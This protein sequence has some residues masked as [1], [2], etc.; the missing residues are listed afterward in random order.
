MRS[1][2]KGTTFDFN[3]TISSQVTINIGTQPYAN[4][5][6]EITVYAYANVGLTYVDTNIQVYF[7][8]TGDLF[9]DIYGSVTIYNGYNCG[10]NTFGGAEF[11]EYT[12]MFDILSISPASSGTQTYVPGSANT[13]TYSCP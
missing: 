11:G 7:Q 2:F 1:Y 12:S 3:F 9:N 5:S 13:N 8:W 6:G 10:S 4:G